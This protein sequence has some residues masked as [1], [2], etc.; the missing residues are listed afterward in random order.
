[1]STIL[2]VHVASS[3]RQNDIVDSLRAI[4]RRFAVACVPA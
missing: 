4:A 1:M 2:T 3:T